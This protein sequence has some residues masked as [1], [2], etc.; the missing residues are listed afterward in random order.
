MFSRILY[1]YIICASARSRFECFSLLL[2]SPK[3]SSGGGRQSA[4]P[5][6][7][8]PRPYLPYYPPWYNPDHTKMWKQFKQSLL[9]ST[10]H[11]SI[12]D[13]K[14]DSKFNIIVAI[15]CGWNVGK[16]IRSHPG[17]WPI[18]VSVIRWPAAF[19]SETKL[20]QLFLRNRV[21]IFRGCIRF[22]LHELKVS[23][24]PPWGAEFSVGRT[25]VLPHLSRQKI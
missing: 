23:E 15:N 19:F 1:L 5:T 21:I 22:C 10:I 3:N 11:L 6:Y 16:K 20:T 25:D 9:L 7:L 24:V 8:L 13:L 14:N 18:R 4:A 2:L 17:L 12:K